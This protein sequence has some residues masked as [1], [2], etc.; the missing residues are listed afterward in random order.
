[1]TDQLID[2]RGVDVRLCAADG[3]PLS[4]GQDAV[5]VIANAGA[6][7]VAVPVARLDPGFFTLASGVAG[8]IVQKFVNYR[9]R[10]AIV[11]DIAGPLAA[12]S[13]LRAFV[14]ESNRRRDCWFVADLAELGARLV[15]DRPSGM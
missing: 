1:M 10:L 7:V 14:A 13:S 6:D 4:T 15:P 11:G 2:L 8:E 9:V 3:P 12:S 5:D